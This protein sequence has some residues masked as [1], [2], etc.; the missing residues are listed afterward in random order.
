MRTGEHIE[1]DPDLLRAGGDGAEP[2]AAAP[3]PGAPIPGTPGRRPSKPTGRAAPGTPLPVPRV[4]EP[5]VGGEPSA[6]RPRVTIPQGVTRPPGPS[7]E[8]LDFTRPRIN[9]VT[10]NTHCDATDDRADFSEYLAGAD[11]SASSDLDDKQMIAAG[12]ERALDGLQKYE[13]G[14]FVELS[15]AEGKRISTRWGH[16][17][18]WDKDAG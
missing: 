2:V 7:D 18:R 13:V 11:L 16:V 3:T 5:R 17:Y 12:I 10:Q 8:A 9:A 15:A 14:H 1:Q 4:H 6:Q